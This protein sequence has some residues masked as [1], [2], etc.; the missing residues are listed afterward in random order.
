M[1]IISGDVSTVKNT[2]IFV[3]LQ[4]GGQRQL[5]V[6]SNEVALENEPSGTMILPVPEPSDVQFVDMTNHKDL[7]DKLDAWPREKGGYLSL[8]GDRSLEVEEVGSYVASKVPNHSAFESL[9]KDKFRVKE[10]VLKYLKQTYPKG[11]SF[12]AFAL[13]PNKSY[14]PFAYSHLAPKDGKMFIP[15]MHFHSHK[16]SKKRG[17]AHADWNHEIYAANATM[18]EN[19]GKPI[20]DRRRM[21]KDEGVTKFNFT[22]VHTVGPVDDFPVPMQAFDSMFGLKIEAPYKK[23]HDVYATLVA[24]K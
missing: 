12:I 1:C 23:N 5:T 10:E 13:E 7:F 8:G 14:H 24:A 19:T 18:D 2:K 3:G 21:S 15:T 6:Y 20:G 4:E 11:Y 16:K 9:D 17:D 22:P